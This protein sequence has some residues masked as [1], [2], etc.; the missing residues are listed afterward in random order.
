MRRG[1]LTLG[2]RQLALLLIVGLLGGCG[3]TS[4]PANVVDS[5][6]ARHE[7]ADGVVLYQNLSELLDTT[8]YVMGDAAPV[9]LTEAVV[10]GRVVEVREGGAFTVE[11]KDAP[12]GTLTTFDDPR[13]HWRT[14]HADL[15]VDEVI[16]GSAQQRVTFGLAL[17]TELDVKAV[18]RDLVGL[19]EV[20][21][22]LARSPVFNDDAVWGTVGDGAL[23]A[24][25]DEHGRLA[26]PV[27]PQSEATQLLAGVQT[28]DDL[29]AAARGP[30]VVITAD[31]TGTERT[32]PT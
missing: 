14:F 21:L 15:V 17:G 6:R 20:V 12:G 25:L 23:L 26:L 5:L 1:G 18:R 10:R 2:V 13:A 11:G 27:L 29:R 22:F 28:I 30:A 16:S 19:G 32:G 3:V 24:T 9:A 8:T 7:V 4:E 31:A